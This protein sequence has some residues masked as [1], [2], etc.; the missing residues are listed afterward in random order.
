MLN[1]SSD[2]CGKIFKF[3]IAD[4]TDKFETKVSN[5][6]CMEMLNF[7]RNYFTEKKYHNFKYEICGKNQIFL[8]A[9]HNS[10]QFVPK[11]SNEISMEMCFIFNVDYRPSS[12]KSKFDMSLF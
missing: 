8:S 4:K 12:K 9:D 3:V 6:I 10:F 7:G 2:I 11:V 1:I 5:D